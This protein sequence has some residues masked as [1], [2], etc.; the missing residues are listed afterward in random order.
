MNAS[1]TQDALH[2]SALKALE[3]A[4]PMARR[5]E[6]ATAHLAQFREGACRA[7]VL[8]Q[9]AAHGTQLGALRFMFADGRTPFALMPSAAA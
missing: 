7:G 1:T 6:L 9:S 5:E 8:L 2:A 3:Q 4:L